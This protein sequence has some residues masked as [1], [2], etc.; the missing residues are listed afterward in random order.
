MASVG[1]DRASIER[2][3][4]SKRGSIIRHA[5]FSRRLI[6]PLLQ[7]AQTH[8][9]RIFGFDTYHFP[10]EAPPRSA[11]ACANSEDGNRF[12]SQRGGHASSLVDAGSPQNIQARRL[13]LLCVY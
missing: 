11:S 13:S 3:C 6:Q 2:C 10:S 8:P 1:N 9:T 7:S 4:L 5:A 12:V